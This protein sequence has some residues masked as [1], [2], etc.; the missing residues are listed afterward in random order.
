MALLRAHCTKNA[1][2]PTTPSSELNI[3]HRFMKKG[4]KYT[5]VAGVVESVSSTAHKNRARPLFAPE[6]MSEDPVRSQCAPLLLDLLLGGEESSWGAS[7]GSI[8]RF[9]RP[10]RGPTFEEVVSPPPPPHCVAATRL[11]EHPRWAKSEA[12]P[13]DGSVP[14]AARIPSVSWVGGQGEWLSRWEDV[15]H[16]KRGFD[17]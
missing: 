14:V 11:P 12:S 13:G 3:S 15:A 4:T 2:R 1:K 17:L 5:H 6:S 7:S 9:G 8:V 16:L 10:R